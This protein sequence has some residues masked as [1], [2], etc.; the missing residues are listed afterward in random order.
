MGDEEEL[1]QLRATV[2]RLSQRVSHLERL[3]EARSEPVTPPLPAVAP[4]LPQIPSPAAARPAASLEDR[5]GSQWLNRA[6]IIAVLVGVSYFL[7]FAFDNEWI[8]P[9]FR[10]L[11]GLV[12]GIAVILWSE[13]FRRRNY[14]LFSWS[15]KAVGIGVLYLSLW[16]SCQQ[17]QLVSASAAFAAMVLVTAATAWMALSQ[18]A[19]VIAAM[20]LVGGFLTPVLLS[21]GQNREVVLF[22][23][24]ALLNLGALAVQRFRPWPRILF[25]A[26]LGTLALYI[27][28]FNTYYSDSQYGVTIFFVGLFFV[29]FAL[30]P[31]VA[32]S[33]VRRSR[34]EGQVVIF[35]PLLNGAVFFFE[36]RSVMTGL[37]ANQ[38]AAAYALGLAIFFYALGVAASRRECEGSRGEPIVPLIH[39]AAAIGF[40]TLAIPLK[41]DG[42]WITLGWLAE[43]AALFWAGA[44]V[45]MPKVKAAACAVFLAAVAHLVLFISTNRAE[46]LFFNERFGLYLAAIAVLGYMIWRQ[47][48]QP[49][50]GRFGTV[51]GVGVVL[52]NVLA[53]LA[54]GL[55]VA[56]YYAQQSILLRQAYGAVVTPEYWHNLRALHI[57]RDFAYSAIAMAYGVGLICIG[58]WRRT[59]FLRWQ[60]IVLIAVTILKVF[61]YDVS[62][63]DRVYRIASFILLGVILL[64]ISFAY[65]KNWLG[66]INQQ[67]R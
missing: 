28:W 27:A 2:E 21:T 49:D 54:L 26:F 19:E 3:L 7:K 42:R 62:A 47:R 9:G 35:L 33:P 64:A 66:L 29:T 63:L 4:A 18:N 8:G 37:D 23:Y 55:E 12:A 16:A 46:T 34:M 51:L 1:R 25:G 61:I 10:V 43:S 60:A 52:L 67:H 32:T 14:P 44:R 56:D 65:Q 30:G 45:V 48:R 20:A 6:G 17:Y 53:L 5:I 38:R 50:A 13:R 58:F 31:I 40:I 22:S 24:V 59:A 11:I 36:V 39:Y 57:E 41:L 15:L